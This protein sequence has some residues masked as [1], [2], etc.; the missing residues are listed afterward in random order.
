MKAT[1]QQYRF[2]TGGVS[3]NMYVKKANYDGA[4]GVVRSHA[5]QIRVP[6]L[7]LRVGRRPWVRLINDVFKRDLPPSGNLTA[8]IV[9]GDGLGQDCI[10]KKEFGDT[11]EKR[12]SRG[13]RVCAL[14]LKQVIPNGQGPKQ[15]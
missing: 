12:A 7:S 6:R 5:W 3:L 4:E 11:Q 10:P 8:R 2:G 15:R 13:C 1:G 9:R 14:N